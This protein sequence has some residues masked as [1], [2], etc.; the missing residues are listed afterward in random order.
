MYNLYNGFIK[1]IC[2]VGNRKFSLPGAASCLLPSANATLDPVNNEILK[3]ELAKYMIC[4]G[5]VALINNYR[6]L[7]WTKISP[8]ENCLAT[9]IEAYI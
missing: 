2:S 6:K 9:A 8:L 4:T 1:N 5:L 3:L 7:V